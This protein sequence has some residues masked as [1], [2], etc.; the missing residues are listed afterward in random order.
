MAR[1]RQTPVGETRAITFAGWQITV[2]RDTETEATLEL[3][4]DRETQAYG[5]AAELELA[6]SFFT[7]TP[8]RSTDTDDPDKAI[9]RG[10][11]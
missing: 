1:L 3:V 8:V 7:S 11:L 6:G 5:Q 4:P 2:R 10:L 9:F